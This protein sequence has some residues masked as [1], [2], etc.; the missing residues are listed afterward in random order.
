MSWNTD[1]DDIFE[2]NEWGKYPPEDLIRFVARNYYK[3][4]DR[5]QVRILEVGCGPGANVWYMAQE[6]FSAYGIDGSR[7]AI[8]RAKQRFAK[9]HL[10]GHFTV[11]DILSLPFEDSFFDA[12]IDIECIYTNSLADTRKIFSEIIRV[13]K[14][15]GKFYSKA[16][17]VGTAGEGKGSEGTGEPNTYR[18]IRDGPL[19][20]FAGTQRF[21]SKEDI[22][23]LYSPFTI[24]SIDYVIRSDNNG[25][26]EIR[27]HLICCSKKRG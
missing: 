8:D 15:N 3:A 18:N 13:L 7:V 12:V 17:M 5:G 25:Q 22:Y 21:I 9:E 2:K 14:P 10:T 20:N 19:S 16:F 24:D 1:W 26:H 27:E 11:G 6:G 4:K 23:R